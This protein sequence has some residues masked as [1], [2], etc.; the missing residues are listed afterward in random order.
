MEQPNY[1]AIIPADVRYDKNLT[2]KEKLLYGEITALSN[3]E[4]YCWASNE[5]FANLYGSSTRTIRSSITK[6]EE[7]GYLRR[8]LIYKKDSKEVEKR[9]LY[10]MTKISSPGEKNF[11]TPEEKN[12]LDNNTSSNI[13]SIN[14][15]EKEIYKEKESFR[16][17]TIEEIDAYCRERNNSVDAEAF[18][19]HYESK[20]WLIGKAKMKSWKAA[21]IT[22]EK[23]N[24]NN[25]APKK[26]K[27]SF[28]F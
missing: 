18:Y 21:V 5:Y 9:L 10:P 25:P 20:G 2:D 6:L 8:Q 27:S 24:K 13:T 22:W 26:K 28:F 23:G 17:P 19:Y 15:K 3:Q 1:Y 4:G 12:F 7:N 16:K 11:P 14:N